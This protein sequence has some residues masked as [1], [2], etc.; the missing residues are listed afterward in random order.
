[1]GACLSIYL[2]ACLVN[3]YP[4]KHYAYMS[5]ILKIIAVFLAGIPFISYA[6]I[7]KDDI[8]PSKDSDIVASQSEGL[9]LLDF[10]LSYLRDTIF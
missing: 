9:D 6:S 5:N 10:I 3:Y 4:S 1:M 8:I 7:Q 2:C